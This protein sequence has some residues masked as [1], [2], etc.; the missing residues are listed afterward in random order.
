MTILRSSALLAIVFCL[1]CGGS[2]TQSWEGKPRTSDSRKKPDFAAAI[3]ND[4]SNDTSPNE[5]NASVEN[6]RGVN[7]HG[8]NPH[9]A[10]NPRQGMEMTSAAADEVLENNGK[11]DI[12]S[13]HWTVPKSWV[14]KTP[15][16]SILQAEYAIPKAEGDKDDGRLT[17][18]EARGSLE[19]NVDRWKG[20]FSK[21]LDKEKQETIDAGA[22]KV[23][24][25]DLTGTF[26]DSRGMMGPTVTRPGYR[27]LGAIFQLPN[28]EGLHFIKC[29]GPVKTIDAHADEFKAFL[30]SFKADKN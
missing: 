1:G 18:S 20:Q 10:M 17:I 15:K 24:L 27:M 28:D 13:A 11:L 7:P 2:S 21:K 22:I 23:T 12:D 3:N 25:V 30:K 29:Y 6:P 16:S 26:D 8:A 14:R 19:S 4:T 5:P 9:G